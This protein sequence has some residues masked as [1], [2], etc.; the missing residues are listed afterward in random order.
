MR[1][2]VWYPASVQLPGHDQPIRRAKVVAT[3]DGVYVYTAV[4]KDDDW[5]P[6]WYA[7]IVKDQPKPPEGSS[8]RARNGFALATE[9]GTLT[10]TMGNGCGCGWPLKRWVPTWQKRIVRWGE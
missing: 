8:S 2:M 1:T 4:P 9:D 6:D 5:T 7:P 10:I 3:P